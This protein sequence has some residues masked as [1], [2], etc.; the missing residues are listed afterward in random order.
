MVRV[1]G[2]VL[3]GVLAVTPR[4]EDGALKWLEATVVCSGAP[5]IALRH[6]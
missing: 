4:H 2:S 3:R 5:M 1:A 6:A